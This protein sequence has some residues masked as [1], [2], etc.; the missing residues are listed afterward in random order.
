ME[1]Y[2]A[3]PA[4]TNLQRR[5]KGQMA[6]QASDFSKDEFGTLR[7]G[8]RICV[9]NQPDLKK[10]ILSEAHESAYSIHPGGTKMYED[11]RQIF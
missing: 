7:F 4:D 6:K 3:Q 8:G 11:L 5:A 1:I 2:K 9:P 10:K